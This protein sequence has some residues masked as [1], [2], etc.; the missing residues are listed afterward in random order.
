MQFRV[1]FAIVS[2]ASIH[3]LSAQ[4]ARIPVYGEAGLG[5]GQ[6]LFMGDIRAK[7]TA[8][9]GGGSFAP[10]AGANA[11]IAFY[12]APDSWRGLGVGARA[13]VFAAGPSAGSN[14]DE[15]FFNYYHIGISAKYYPISRTFNRGLYVRGSFGPGQLTTKRANEASRTYVHQFAVGSTALL[16]VGFSIPVGSKTIGLEAEYET[17][18]RSGT[19]N[20]LG[21]GQTFSSGQF[22]VNVKLGF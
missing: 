22:G 5:F 2:L 3:S 19:I 1:A 18:S 9:V 8:S 21:D 16:G 12:V 14:G 13:K 15:H 11:L 17:S 6:T 20:G 7:L 4:N 10:N